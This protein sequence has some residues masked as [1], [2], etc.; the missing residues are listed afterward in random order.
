MNTSIFK[1]LTLAGL[2]SAMPMLATAADEMTRPGPDREKREAMAQQRA[3]QREGIR[4]RWEAMSPEEQRAAR[5]AMRERTDGRRDAAREQ[6]DSMSPEEQ[7]A[8][9]QR[10]Q[11]RRDNLRERYNQ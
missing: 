2:L 7:D 1:V 10:A 9:R 11:E 5:E 3:E 8:L 4:E 6:W